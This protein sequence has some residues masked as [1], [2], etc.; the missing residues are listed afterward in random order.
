MLS[1]VLQSATANALDR[2]LLTGGVLGSATA[3]TIRLG[4][5]GGKNP[6][7]DGVI[8]FLLPAVPVGYKVASADFSFQLASTPRTAAGS[9]DVYALGARTTGAV[10]GTDF[11]LGAY[12]GDATDATAIQSAILIANTAK[13]RIS[14]NATADAALGGFLTSQYAAGAAGKYVF[15]RLNDKVA[16]AKGQV[17][18]INSANATASLRPTLTITFTPLVVAPAAPSAVNL[19]PLSSSSIQVKWQDNS[20]NETGFAIERSTDDVTF[21]VAGSVGASQTSFLDVGLSGDTKYFYRVRAVNSTSNAT[22]YSTYAPEAS[23]RTLLATPIAPAISQ[24]TPLSS[25]SIQVQWL[26]NSTTETGFVIERSTDDIAF[27]VAGSANA[28]ETFFNDVGLSPGALYYYRVRAVNQTVYSDYSPEASTSTLPPPAPVAPSGLSLTTLANGSMQVQWQDNS[29]NETGFIV[30]RSTDDVNFIAAAPLDANATSLTD[31]GLLADTKY[32]YRVRAINDPTFSAYSAEAI[33]TTLPAF[34][35]TVWVSNSYSGATSDGG[36]ATPFKTIAAAMSQAQ[37]GDGIVLRAG[38]YR[39]TVTMKSGTPDA[40][41]TLMGEPGERATIS[42]F[43]ALTGWS[44]SAT[45]PNIYETTSA[46]V[47][48]NLFVGFTQ[49]EISRSPNEGWWT[50]TSPPLTDGATVTLTDTTDL[51]G[52]PNLVGKTILAYIVGVNDYRSVTILSHDQVAGTITV[53]DTGNSSNFVNASTYMVRNGP[54]LLDRPGE[55]A[56]VRQADGSYKVYFW[57]K[58]LSD[59]NNTQTKS[60]TSYLITAAANNVVIRNLEL[61]GGKSGV[62]AVSNSSANYTNITVTQNIFHDNT[63][64]VD[65]R[66]VDH[67]TVTHNLLTTNDIGVRVAWATNVLIDQNEIA[68]SGSDAIILCGDWL[69]KKP[70]DI[71]FRGS[72]NLVVSN[73]YIHDALGTGHPDGI[74]TYYSPT[75]IKILNNAITNAG[76]A[77]MLQDTGPTEIGGNLIYSTFNNAVNLTGAVSLHNNTIVGAGYAPMSFYAGTLG[78]GPYTAVENVFVGSIVVPSV[79]AGD[80]NL[81]APAP[82]GLGVINNKSLDVYRSA[83]PTLEL[84]SVQATPQFVNAPY[85]HGVVNS[86]TNNTRNSLSLRDV[87]AF[88]VGDHVEVNGDGVVRTLT[89]VNKTAKT[90]TF[91]VALPRIPTARSVV[92][93]WKTSTN[94]V[95]DLRLALGSPGYVLGATGGSVGTAIALTSY[96]AGDYNNDGQRDLPTQYADVAAAIP[97]P[98]DLPLY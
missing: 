88:A 74:Q 56:N 75:N 86:D 20:T 12:S 98:N 71:G 73:N 80:R 26:D 93:D 42:G 82:P 65:F 7:A 27:T 87:T 59:L 85:A 40:P 11:Y 76:Q 29:D 61:A 51:V 30:E 5:V 62:T 84:N 58:D 50:W 21:T 23:T 32:F 83:N 34:T 69:A 43:K 60:N 47:P 33:D 15:I 63:L 24:L 9:I 16:E 39:E 49:Q 52:G 44:P 38:T 68:F 54:E 17:W 53:A 92:E 57:P 25:S 19:T 46:T 77:I 81:Y 90:I 36:F 97:K 10:L 14:T 31:T 78:N 79:Y 96:I 66:P 28:N 1:D 3:T 2:E 64:A 67:L 89:A 41:I 37:P 72:D 94:F 91:D 35:R 6:S 45:L 18:S 70:T 48:P 22:V 4:Y 13:G 8:P 95:V 55:W